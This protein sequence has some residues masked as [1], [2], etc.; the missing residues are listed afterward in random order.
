MTLHES[1]TKLTEINNNIAE[2]LKEREN[3]LKEWSVA[4]NTENQDEITCVAEGIGITDEVYYLYLINGDSKMLACHIHWDYKKCS[5]NDFYKQID[6]S[7]HLL[8]VANG[9][10]Y[11]IPEFQ[12]NLVYAKA[13]EIR[14]HA[15]EALNCSDVGSPSG[16]VS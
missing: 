16:S 4:F 7:M 11:E 13:M 14:D 3:V 9:R 2:L 5:I 6:T 1:E 8:S 10:G 12:R 15:R